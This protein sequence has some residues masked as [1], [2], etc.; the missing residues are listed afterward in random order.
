MA[1]LPHGF[2]ASLSRLTR[3]HCLAESWFQVEDHNEKDTHCLHNDF[4][5]VVDMGDNMIINGIEYHCLASQ[6]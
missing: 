3:E 4:Q 2:G 6:I 1:T 5:C